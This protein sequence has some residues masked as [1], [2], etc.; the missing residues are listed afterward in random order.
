MKSE[1]TFV[2]LALAVLFVI[3]T[4]LGWIAFSTGGAVRRQMDSGSIWFDGNDS[5]LPAD[6]TVGFRGLLYGGGAGDENTQKVF[7]ERVRAFMAE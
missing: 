1:G 7:L 5:R 6:F 4:V 3:V 2:K